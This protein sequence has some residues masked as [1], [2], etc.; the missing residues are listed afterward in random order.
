MTKKE[1]I[2]DKIYKVANM[3][4]KDGNLMLDE[5][6]ITDAIEEGLDTTRKDTKKEIREWAGNNKKKDVF[7]DPVK[8]GYNHALSDLGRFLKKL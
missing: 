1:K 7:F 6:G 5:S 2:L 3:A 8:G 4:F